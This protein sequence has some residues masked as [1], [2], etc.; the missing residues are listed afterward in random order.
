MAM[1]M[2][3]LMAVLLAR[4]PHPFGARIM[5]QNLNILGY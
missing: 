3:V 1:A 4:G 2:T 5:A